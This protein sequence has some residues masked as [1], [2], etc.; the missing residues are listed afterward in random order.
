MR[1]QRTAS[2]SNED[3]NNNDNS[4]NNDNPNE[5]TSGNAFSRRRSS[6]DEDM[7]DE[8]YRKKLEY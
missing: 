2:E 7:N 1:R 4:I 5:M 6:V 3:E 8:R